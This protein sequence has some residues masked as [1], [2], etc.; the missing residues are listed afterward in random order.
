MKIYI[1]GDIN[2]E[3]Y[4][5]LA[6][7]L[8]LAAESGELSVCVELTS[9]GGDAEV[10][11]AMANRL[12]TGLLEITVAIRGYAHSAA[13]LPLA[14]AKHRVMAKEAT[15][16]VH[17]DSVHKFSGTVSEFEKHAQHLRRMEDRWCQ[18]MAYA[19]TTP[20]ETW[21]LLHKN[22]TYLSAEE[23]LALGLIDEII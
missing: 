16:M 11:L 21:A 14:Y 13:V 6:T 3:A 10:A 23:C 2:E 22:E 12:R 5:H 1:T 15:V 20:K 4:Q 9:G 18:F 19:T 7:Q 8:D 17:E